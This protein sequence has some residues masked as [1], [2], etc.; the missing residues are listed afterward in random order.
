[1]EWI[2]LKIFKLGSSVGATVV[3]IKIFQVSKGSSICVY[4][5]TFKLI[6]KNNFIGVYT[7]ISS[8]YEW[9][10]Q[11]VCEKSSHPPVSFHCFD[12]D[13]KEQKIIIEFDVENGG[14]EVANKVEIDI[15]NGD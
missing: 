12:G 5:A 7:R 3:R 4:I 15:H 10:R 9:V 6:S 1:M 8:Y 2:Q 13:N 14:E 11:H